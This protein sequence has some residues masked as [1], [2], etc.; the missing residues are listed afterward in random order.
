M[1][2][3]W[4]A[5]KWAAQ[6]HVVSGNLVRCMIVPAVTDVCRPQDTHSWV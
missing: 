4:V 3:E 5:I 2:L 6:N 1:P